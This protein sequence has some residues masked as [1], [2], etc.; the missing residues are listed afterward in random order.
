MLRHECGTDG[1][2][3]G[4][5]THGGLR[6]RNGP[7]IRTFAFIAVAILLAAAGWRAAI[8]GVMPV[9]SRDGVTFCLYARGLEEHG[10]QYLRTPEAIQ[11]PLY[12]AM[13]LGLERAAR[14]VGA[15][16]GPMTWQR[17]GQLLSLLAGLAV[18]ALAGALTA[19]VA[20]R[21]RLHVRPDVAA[22]LAMCLAAVLDLNV[23][24]S[25]DAM[26]DQLHL[27]LYLAA[28]LLLT[29]LAS[30]RAAAA[31]GLL[32]GL[33]FL[34]RQ[35]GL[36]PAVAGLVVL[37]VS[38]RRA[39]LPGLTGRAALLM[40]GFLVCAAP[41][42]AAVGR[43]STKKDVFRWLQQETAAG[44]SVELSHILSAFG[45]RRPIG[46]ARDGAGTC[47]FAL[48]LRQADTRWGQPSKVA[49]EDR[50]GDPTQGVPRAQGRDVAWAR[51]RGGDWQARLRT[52]EVEWYMLAPH[53]LYK[54]LR[55]GR[56]VVPVLAFV[57]MARMGR[58]LW[59]EELRGLT[60]CA[61]GH[62]ALGIVL[63]EAYGYLDP[64]H[65][66]VVVM[67][68]TPFAAAAL[69]WMA[70]ALPRRGQRVAPAVVVA[71]A[72]LPL[73]AYS[74]RVPHRQDAHLARA[75]EWL[76]SHAPD[77][78]GQR[79]LCSESPRRTAFYAEMVW[80]AWRDEPTDFGVLVSQITAEKGGYFA[81]ELGP[82]GDRRYETL[83]NRELLVRL[84]GDVRVAPHL[85]LMHVEP[86]PD[87]GEL[88]LYALRPRGFTGRSAAEPRRG[89]QR[90][91]ADPSGWGSDQARVPWVGGGEDG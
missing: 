26:S 1:A 87:G 62:F 30:W 51:G 64:R 68:L 27:A 9:I 32:S 65:M 14:W 17:C 19:D 28:V 55:A 33:A 35:E 74:L 46:A 38:W 72:M 16:A 57:A 47:P 45:E 10:L 49:L 36:M 69:A 13:L 75:A 88:R 77:S 56:V 3:N 40:L 7:R 22:L 63:L 53:A 12:P 5:T 83:G 86:R 21:V 78:R 39:P 42:W 29:R 24:L 20:R 67:L 59:G 81:I 31:C 85:H 15:P 58:R 23:W 50:C 11:H 2:A 4:L 82:P 41:Y 54:L 84:E 61:A 79:M 60:T 71:A 18:V 43:F 6:T 80:E 8:A 89:A 70:D 34:T 66:L 90:S 25:A 37:A 44:E 73:A 91:R 52:V 48:A 76:R